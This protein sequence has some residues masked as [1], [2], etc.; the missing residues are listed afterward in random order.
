MRVSFVVW[1]P[2]LLTQLAEDPV[3]LRPAQRPAIPADEQI[4]AIR[5]WS[6][7]PVSPYGLGLV[8]G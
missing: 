2:N 3:E 6:L 1:D 4:G 8:S 5:L 7:S